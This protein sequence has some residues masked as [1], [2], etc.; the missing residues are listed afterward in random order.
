[1]I[2]AYRGLGLLGIG[3]PCITS[4]IA[5]LI[6]DSIF[7]EDYYSNHPVVHSFVLVIAAAIIWI[8]GIRLNSDPNQLSIP[9]QTGQQPEVRKKHMIFWMPLQYFSIVIVALSIYYVLEL[10]I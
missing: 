2:I 3:I 8:V 6:L 1:M 4:L 7:G 10:S 9:T 5:Q